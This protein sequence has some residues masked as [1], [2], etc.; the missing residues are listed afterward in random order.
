MKVLIQENL[1]PLVLRGNPFLDRFCFDVEKART[2]KEIVKKVKQEIPALVVIDHSKDHDDM[3][4]VIDDVR[5]KFGFK[6]MKIISAIPFFRRD[7]LLS[8][9]EVGAD[10]YIFYPI[11]VR[12]FS[13]K[14]SAL[15]KIPIRRKKR[16]PALFESLTRNQGTIFP[17]FIRDISESGISFE[18]KQPLTNDETLIHSLRLFQ[19]EPNI[20]IYS[21]VVWAVRDSRR[22][23]YRYG[24]TFFNVNPLDKDMIGRYVFSRTK[25]MPALSI[26]AKAA[27]PV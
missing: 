5:N 4:K 23:L 10:D 12:E 6:E 9:L 26:H 22:D 11:E 3:L 1:Y 27:L 14:V 24:S 21:K 15:L 7:I 8:C 16:S 20:Y 25:D 19:G 18:A 17:I 13:N 2:P